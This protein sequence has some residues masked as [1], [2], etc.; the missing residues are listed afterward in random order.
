M[1]HLQKYRDT[2]DT[3]DD[4]LVALFAKRFSVVT[5]IGKYKKAHRIPIINKDQEQKRLQILFKKA[6]AYNLSKEFIAN[7]WQAIFVESYRLEK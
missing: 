5:K 7:A 1:D 2:I 4:R 6:K 3:I